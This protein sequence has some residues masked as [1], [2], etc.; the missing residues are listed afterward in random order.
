M[1]LKTN[2]PFTKGPKKNIRNKKNKD[3]LTKIIYNK[4]G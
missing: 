1:K 4:L 3:Q 2:K